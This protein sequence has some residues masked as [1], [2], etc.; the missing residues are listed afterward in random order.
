MLRVDLFGQRAQQILVIARRCNARPIRRSPIKFRGIRHGPIRRGAI[1]LPSS[2]RSALRCG[3][4]K[5][6]RLER[7]NI[8]L[9]IKAQVI[10]PRHRRLI[11]RVRRSSLHFSTRAWFSRRIL[12]GRGRGAHRLS[13]DLS[14]LRY[15]RLRGVLSLAA[16]A[17]LIAAFL[18][19][20]QG[21]GQGCSRFGLF[22]RLSGVFTSLL[23]IKLLLGHLQLMG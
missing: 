17:L 11:R 7:S 21:R 9:V 16:L 4:I 6:A 13:N 19:R 18:L 12:F 3:A 23:F 15:Y 1:E 8:L 14:G 22:L 2:A 20:C 10:G 5:R